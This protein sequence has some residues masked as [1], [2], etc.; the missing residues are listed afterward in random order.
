MQAPVKM[1]LG[2]VRKEKA[3]RSRGEIG[4]YSSTSSVVTYSNWY[5]SMNSSVRGRDKQATNT[6]QP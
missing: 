2:V 4:V 1:S 3:E 6:R 5:S